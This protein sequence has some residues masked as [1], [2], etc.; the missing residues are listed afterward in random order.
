MPRPSGRQCLDISRIPA[1]YCGSA[2]TR[3][4]RNGARP[5]KAGAVLRLLLWAWA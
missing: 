1:R 2:G 4:K 5:L 3:G